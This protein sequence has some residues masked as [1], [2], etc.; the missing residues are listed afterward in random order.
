MS[1]VEVVAE[2]VGMVTPEF[3]TSWIQAATCVELVGGIWS[4]AG[5]VP[6]V[7]VPKIARNGGQ[8]Q[9]IKGDPEGDG[10]E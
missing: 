9:R 1:T 7:N 2:N 6:G 3:A 10:L 4:N 8:R 5:N